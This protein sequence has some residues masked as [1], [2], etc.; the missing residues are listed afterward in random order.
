MTGSR[1]GVVGAGVMGVG[2]AQC[3]AAAGHTVTLTDTDSDALGTV[4]GRL[5]TGLR[6]AR[7]LGRGGATFDDVVDRV[8]CTDLLAD[9]GD[10]DFVVECVR[11]RVPD[12]QRV[13][14]ELDAVCPP[15]TVLA[16]CTSAVSIARLAE[17]TGRPDRVLGT[18]FMNPAPLKDTVEVVRTATTGERTLRTT[19][20]LL[21]TMDKT[22]IVVGDAPGFVSNRVLM[23]TINEAA[24][25]V[26]QGTATAAQVDEVFES[27]FGH[28]MGPL[29]T[30]DLIGLD[31]V[32]DTL[33]VLREQTGDR[34]FTPCPLLADLVRAGRTGRKTGCGFHDYPAAAVP[35]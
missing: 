24:T 21:G 30:G 14:A 33:D 25:V 11:E 2:I 18:H 28:P 17:V 32:L 8:L 3:L 7:L 16:S 26:A 31:T 10:V 12:K 4:V 15:D 9:L 23:L 35:R 13:F 6:Q 29:R 19:L 34:R 27:C 20:D 1:V 5:R 22:A